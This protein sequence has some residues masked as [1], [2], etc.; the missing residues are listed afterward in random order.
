MAPKKGGGKEVNFFQVL[1]KGYPT[2]SKN[3]KLQNFF[4]GNICN[5]VTFL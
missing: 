1:P 2:G 5:K 3:E 4:S